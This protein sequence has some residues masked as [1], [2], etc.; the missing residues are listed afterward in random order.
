LIICLS[1]LFCF[2]SL[3]FFS[4]L[5]TCVCCQRTHQGGD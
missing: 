1:F 2:Y 5:V 4:E 3:S